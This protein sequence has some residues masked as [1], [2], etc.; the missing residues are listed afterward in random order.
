VRVLGFGTGLDEG[1]T[2]DSARVVA[3]A[4]PGVS[5]AYHAFLEQRD[6]R[7]S[8][9]PNAQRFAELVDALAPETRHLALH[10]GHLSLVSVANEECDEIVISI[11][12]NPTQ[13]GP[14][15]DFSKYPRPLDQDLEMAEAAGCTV[16]FVPTVEEV[17]PRKTTKVVVSEVTEL[18]EGAHRPGHFDGVS[19]V[20]LKLFNMVRPHLAYFGLKELQQ[21]AV[22]RR[23]VEDLNVPIQLRF[24]ETLREQDGLAMSSRNRYLSVQER[25]VAPLLYGTLLEIR[26]KVFSNPENAEDILAAARA[27][28]SQSGFQL[29]YLDLVNPDSMQRASLADKELAVVVA[30]KLGTTRLIDNVR[31]TR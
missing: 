27:F 4:G 31:F 11:F 8:T 23:M 29:D 28:V 25:E 15:E 9:L 17:Y 1:E 5:V 22:I 19:T 3:T 26:D 20:V 7:L 21:C 16:A 13:F 14:N 10:E 12:V 24:Q 18:Y 30:A 6:E 2:L